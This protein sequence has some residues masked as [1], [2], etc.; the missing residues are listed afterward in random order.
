MSLLNQ[1]RIFTRVAELASFTGAATDLGLPKAS[2]STAVQQLEQALGTRLLHRTTRSVVLTQDG[3][4][5]YERGKDALADMDELQTMFQLPASNALTGRIRIDMSTI[6]ARCAVLPRLHELLAQHPQLEIEL[7]STERRVDLVSEGFDCVV[8]AG[9]VTDPG[10]VARPLCDM[11]M[12]NCASPDYLARHGTPRTLDDLAH[13]HL[14]HYAATLGARSTGFEYTDGSTDCALAM[15]GPV[16]VNNAEAY[17]TAC[18]AGLGLIQA[19]LPGARELLE[20]GRLVEVLPEYTA[21][22][23][24]LSLVYANRRNLPARVR[25]VMDWLSQVLERYVQPLEYGQP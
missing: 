18:L 10:L 21:R 20:H 22:P 9:K 1:M 3:Q 25:V 11:P 12:V 14:V 8:R 19:P 5:F 24:P 15:R 17:Q 6:L 4:A 16:T 2:V 23:M 7:S 13:H